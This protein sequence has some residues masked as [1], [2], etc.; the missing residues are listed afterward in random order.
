MNQTENV[1]NFVLHVRSNYISLVNTRYYIVIR[2]Y[3]TRENIA[4]GVHSMK[5]F[6]ILY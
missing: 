1:L 2:G 4:S 6:S 3:A 5:Y